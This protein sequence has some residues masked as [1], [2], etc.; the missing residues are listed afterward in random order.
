MGKEKGWERGEG[1]RNAVFPACGGDF[2]GWEVGEGEF[3]MQT[4]EFGGGDVD[5]EGVYGCHGLRFRKWCAAQ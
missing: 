1:Q 3:L 5:F 4:F 2:V